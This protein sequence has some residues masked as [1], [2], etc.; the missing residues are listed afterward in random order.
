MTLARISPPAVT[1]AAHVSS[2]DVSMPRINWSPGEADVRHVVEA[3]D[4]RRRRAPH[5]HRVL[6]VVLVVARAQAGRR[7]A[8]AL[9]ELDRGRVRGPHLECD[10]RVVASDPR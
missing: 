7:E 1:T 9:V 3:A 5:D 10:A 4:E 8:K 2:H 6:A